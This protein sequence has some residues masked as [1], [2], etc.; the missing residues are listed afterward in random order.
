MVCVA[1]T[2]WTIRR[3]TDFSALG[4]SRWKASHSGRCKRALPFELK[5][6]LSR[7]TSQPNIRACLYCG[8]AAA[9]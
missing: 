8:F 3:P 6:W 1:I 7:G 2:A 5:L 9:C 4:I